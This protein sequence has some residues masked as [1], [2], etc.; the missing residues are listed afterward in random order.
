MILGDDGPAVRQQSDMA[1][2]TVHHR[3]NSERHAL[4]YLNARAGRSVVQHL[5]IFMKAFADTVQPVLPVTESTASRCLSFPIFPE[6][7]EQQVEMV[8]EA[9]LSAR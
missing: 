1:F 5:G 8:C 7:T 2:S 9:M 4:A 3:F 6:M